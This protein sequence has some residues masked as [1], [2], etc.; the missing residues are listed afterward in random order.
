MNCSGDNILTN[1]EVLVEIEK[2]DELIKSLNNLD[3]FQGNTGALVALLSRL[4]QVFHGS[5]TSK[6]NFYFR[7]LTPLEIKSF[8]NCTYRPIKGYISIL[9]LYNLW[10]P[11]ENIEKRRKSKSM[12][13][14]TK[15][16]CDGIRTLENLLYTS[17]QDDTLYATSISQISELATVANSVVDFFN[18]EEEKN[19]GQYFYYL[20]LPDFFCDVHTNDISGL[21]RDQSKISIMYI[22][23]SLLGNDINAAKAIVSHEIAHQVGSLS[24]KRKLRFNCLI[25]SFLTYVF[26]SAFALEDEELDNDFASIVDKFVAAISKTVCEYLLDF[27]PYMYYLGAIQDVLQTTDY[28]LYLFDP[29]RFRDDLTVKKDI[30]SN[31][32]NEFLNLSDK[33]RNK[34]YSWLNNWLNTH[35]F[36][37]KSQDLDSIVELL[38]NRLEN[39]CEALIDDGKAYEEYVD[40]CSAVIQS[41][42]ESYADLRMI[43]YH[44][45]KSFEE[46]VRIYEKCNL[47]FELNKNYECDFRSNAVRHYF[48]AVQNHDFSIERVSMFIINMAQEILNDYII[49]CSFK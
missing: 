13:S 7:T 16:L 44:N 23:T 20:I 41:F 38:Y 6:T 47:S 31:W 1:E 49:A 24:R 10:E 3:D 37:N 25:K 29:N 39:Y 18:D 36:H 35:L 27:D 28:L 34:I 43:E 17:Q 14:M 26:S 12:Y 40:Y 42:S 4:S 21:N 11:E 45:I 2:F 8:I 22:P 9:E 30:C 19:N 48:N 32:K 5:I 15:E 46:Y 33:Q